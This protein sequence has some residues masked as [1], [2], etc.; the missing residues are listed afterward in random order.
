MPDKTINTLDEWI[1]VLVAVLE[2]RGTP[3]DVSEAMKLTAKICGVS[4]VRMVY[5]VNSA[6]EDG[7]VVQDVRSATLRLP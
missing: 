4:V 2:D 1:G 6:V 5:V 7:L 3:M